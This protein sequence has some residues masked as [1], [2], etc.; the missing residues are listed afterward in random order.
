M[1]I[2]AKAIVNLVI[3]LFIAM[4]MISQE[5]GMAAHNAATPDQ[6]FLSDK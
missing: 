5:V 1:S 4:M 3:F 2:K 6:H